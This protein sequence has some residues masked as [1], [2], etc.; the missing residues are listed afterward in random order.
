MLDGT[1][2]NQSTSDIRA[3]NQPQFS[4]KTEMNFM[5]RKAAFDLQPRELVVLGMP[6][7]GI[8]VMMKLIR[9]NLESPNNVKLCK[10]FSES[11]SD[12]CGGIWPHTHPSRMEE[13]PDLLRD[14]RPEDW[15]DLK[16]A[17]AVV[18]IRHPFSQLRSM[19]HGIN[20]MDCSDLSDE[21]WLKRPCNSRQSEMLST[22]EGKQL[23]TE[24]SCR[25]S[26]QSDNSP[27]WP[28]LVSAWN[29]YSYGYLHSLS[30]VFHKV[31]FVRYE[32]LLDNPTPT[33]QQI[34]Y[35]T[36]VTMHEP[37]KEMNTND[38]TLAKF[39]S[40]KYSTN[41]TD[42]EVSDI[43]EQLH[44]PLLY[45][46]GYT[47]CQALDS[48]IVSGAQGADQSTD[49]ASEQ[50]QG[51]Q[52]SGE[53]QQEEQQEEMLSLPSDD[54]QQQSAQIDEEQLIA[55]PTVHTFNVAQTPNWSNYTVEE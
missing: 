17:V 31:I 3:S 39:H 27:C 10:T 20:F 50:Q 40:P 23:L 7:T 38:E 22:L 2:L 25:D 16:E 53:E 29:S 30:K 14:K 54:Q 1:C 46:L 13:Y 9:S 26:V 32:D 8:N 43:C 34:A 15:Q 42:A 24:A 28:S 37:I 4:M 51:E 44:L 49:L 41:Y 55:G 6:D 47:A 11:K 33:L 5:R 48:D 18:V 12:D 52:D 21:G 35:S 45:E 19:Q 36:N